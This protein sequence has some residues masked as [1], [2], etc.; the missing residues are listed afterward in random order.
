MNALTRIHLAFRETVAETKVASYFVTPGLGLALLLILT[1]AHFSGGQV[2]YW[3]VPPDGL[4]ALLIVLGFFP[5]F[6]ISVS[7]FTA[8]LKDRGR[9][10]HFL[11]LPLSN[12]ERFGVSM[13][14]H[15]VFVPLITFGPLFLLGFLLQTIGPSW[16]MWP[17]LR[18]WGMPI[19][20]SLA[21]YYACLIFWLFPSVAAPRYT[22]VI[23]IGL[24]ALGA[25]ATYVVY[26]SLSAGN[27]E[28]ALDTAVFSDRAVVGMH[29]IAQ[30]SEE[31]P[32][33]SI[34]SHTAS[35]GIGPWAY[36]L[37]AP[38]LLAAAYRALTLK[39]A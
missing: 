27:P 7:F 16:F 39:Q 25:F 9:A 22:V 10:E 31:A 29:T 24:V 23:L 2:D 35:D 5:A 15:A 33:E 32:V 38:F 20:L 26:D 34:H 12:G 21:V 17:D 13:L 3:E 18:Y 8:R 6:A 36:V 4:A 14:Y 28:F 37:A 30:Y 1:Y 19:V 11:S